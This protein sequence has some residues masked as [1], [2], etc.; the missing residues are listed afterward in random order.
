[1]HNVWYKIAG[2]A[3][4]LTMAACESST[5]TNQRPITLSFASQTDVGTA[6]RASSVANDITITVGSNTVVITKAQLVIRR[7]Q[8][9]QGDETACVDS[10][11]DAPN[12]DAGEC[13]EIKT[14]PIL[15]DLPLNGTA[16][17]E[18]SASVPEGTYH[19]VHFH[20]HKPT[21]SAADQTFLAANPA[22]ANTSIRVEGTFN[23]QPFVYTSDLTANVNLEFDPPI[24]IDADNKNVTVQVSLNSWFKVNGQV[25][26]P[27]TANKGGANE[28]AVANNIRLSLRAYKDD[29]HDGNED[30]S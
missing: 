6:T 30:D 20:I 14:G 23:G 17:V 28:S 5:G 11:D 19:E 15:V 7:L 1:M 16:D 22:F 27:R 12:P 21:S 18:V 2:P 3:A 25:I 13:A 29:D 26:D 10:D 24:V 4:L 9:E 8:L